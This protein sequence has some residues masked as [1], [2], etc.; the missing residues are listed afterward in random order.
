MTL[1][2]GSSQRRLV[3]AGALAGL[4]ILTR[5]TLVAAT[6][7]G[8]LWLWPSGLR[9][10]LLFAATALVTAL[11]VCLV[12]EVTTGAFV[13]STVAAN[14]NPFALEA[15]ALN[16]GEL[17]LFQGGP[18][19]AAALYFRRRTRAWSAKEEKLLVYYWIASML[20]LIGLAK[21]GSSQNYWIELA[22]VTA[23]LATLALWDCLQDRTIPATRLLRRMLLLGVTT[24][25]SAAL[26]GPS[27]TAGL[28]HFRW[29]E[30]RA[31]EFT[32]VVARVRSEPRQV[33]AQ[34]LDVVVLAGRPILYEPTIFGI[35]HGQGRWDA[36]PL[37]HGICS[38]QIGLL[39][40]DFPLESDGHAIHGYS[41][42]PPPILAALR[43]TMVFETER[44]GKSL[45]VLRSD[46][47][48]G[49]CEGLPQ[50]T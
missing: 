43:E 39:V 2:G 32:A 25:A 18:L 42:W 47:P 11:G 16:V 3:V 5:Q 26:I 49:V 46:R 48:G 9:R 45:Y 13:A 14:A 50:G 20:P 23:V 12:L 34:T 44:A 17:L 19:A 31:V 35:Y 8:A 36:G 40:L 22:A 7:A 24:I 30:S 41:L 21:I 29:S 1:T 10:S 4:A 37:V 28:S 6:I 27:A 33:L 38:G 15:L